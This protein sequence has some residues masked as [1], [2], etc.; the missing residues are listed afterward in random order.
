M[1]GVYKTLKKNGQT[2]YRVSVTFRGKHISLGSFSTEKKAG[3]CYT[4]AREL[5]ASKDASVEDYSSRLALPFDK[6]VS[7][8]N[9]KLNNIYSPNP[10]FVRK[11]FFFYY[12]TPKKILTFDLDDL[13]YFSSHKIMQR[14]GHL[15]VDDF[16]VQTSLLS[17][18]NIQPYAVEGK[19]YRFRNGDELDFRSENLEII[20]P[21]FGVRKEPEGVS[22][23][24]RV[25]IHE[26]STLLV[27]VYEDL[28]TA[29]I[30]YN[31]AVDILK[32]NGCT[33]SFQE[34][35]LEGVSPSA[36][37]DIYS[38]VKI[39]KAIYQRKFSN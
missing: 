7:I 30:A 9:F 4:E 1:P 13:F 38:K 5:I 16:G 34:N 25:K 6:Y 28:I 29:A 39:R 22:T 35:F 19:D 24:Y 8:L 17:R 18:F 37:A 20:N 11:R 26:R 14:G 23:V 36:Y 2:Y 15:F 31:K 27:G 21:Y 33:K 3:R 10:I 12:L 32:R